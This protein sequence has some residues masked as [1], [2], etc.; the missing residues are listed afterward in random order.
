MPGLVPGIH[1]FAASTRQHV[2]GRDQPGHDDAGTW[3]ASILL[4]AERRTERMARINPD[5]PAFAREEFQFLQRDRT[6]TV[7]GMTVDVGVKLRREELAV[8]HVDHE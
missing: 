3:C 6:A 8:E 1:V 2:D 4:L 7:F 5:N